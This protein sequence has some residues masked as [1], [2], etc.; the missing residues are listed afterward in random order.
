MMTQI[1]SA[2]LANGRKVIL[3]GFKSVC[4]CD[5]CGKEKMTVFNK[6]EGKYKLPDDW[7]RIIF[8]DGIMTCELHFCEKCA[9]KY[10][11]LVKHFLT[12]SDVLN[13]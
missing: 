9:D 12:D 5:K 7:N 4:K 6:T 11:K 2:L 3:M 8:Y 1:G 13:E 10:E